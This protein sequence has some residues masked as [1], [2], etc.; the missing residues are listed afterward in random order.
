MN[1]LSNKT[2]RLYIGL[3]AFFLTNALVAEFMG[4][5]IFSLEDTLGIS[6]LS[7]SVFGEKINGISLTCGVLLWPFV[8]V[9][10]D[11]IN[12]YFGVKGVR[13]LSIMAACMIGYAF[14]ML[15]SAMNVIPAGWWIYSSNLG[16]DLNM[17]HAYNSVFGQG[18]NII[19]GS[20]AAFLIGQI[21]DVTVFHQVKKITGEKYI[22]LRST[23]STLVSQLI[24]SF[25]VLFVA[26]Y[27]AR[28]GL[29]NQWSVQLVLAVG[30]V[31]YIYKFLM[32]LLMTPVIYAVHAF[33]DGYLG[34]EQSD[35]LKQ[36]A[37]A[38]KDSL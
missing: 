15:Y 30:T 7:F 26:F 17:D 31:N 8:F 12:E 24:D 35:R 9:M 28:I 6:Q 25:V 27:V 3:A 20:L 14:F 32:A 5:K 11:I 19:L 13:F 22:W 18:L 33:I 34:K 38:G 29:K 2:N 16:N 21:V 36:E 37:I 10:T 23:G 4:V 1:L